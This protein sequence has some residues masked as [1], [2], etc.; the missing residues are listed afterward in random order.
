MDNFSRL[1]IITFTFLITA[2]FPHNN[3]AQAIDKTATGNIKESLILLTENF[4]SINSALDSINAQQVILENHNYSEWVELEKVRL[5]Y[6]DDM[7]AYYVGIIAIISSCIMI[8]LICAIP[9]FL[10]CSFIYRKRTYRY[11]IIEKAIENNIPIPESILTDWESQNK[12]NEKSSQLQSALV[13][14]AWGLGI[15][16]FFLICGLYE[17]AG[18][19]SIPLLV[20][21]AK[22]ITY[23]IERRN[24]LHQE[25][26]KDEN[27][28][29]PL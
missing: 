21:M 28:V 2:L 8:V 18:I 3:S 13:W 4:D 20:G 14:I 5:S 29:D 19:S 7:M 9:V 16:I 12:G 11:R 24:I 1:T 25:T 22:L 10:I 15:I 27:D 6:E 23:F 26:A 17:M